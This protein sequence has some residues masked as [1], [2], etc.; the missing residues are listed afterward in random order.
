MGGGWGDEGC[1]FEEAGGG[2]HEG[3]GVVTG[4]EGSGLE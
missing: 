3:A 2:E 1:G 4:G